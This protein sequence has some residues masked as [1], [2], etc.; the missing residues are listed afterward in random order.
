MRHTF[1]YGIKPLV[2][3]R[4]RLAIRGWLTRRKRERTGEVWPILPGS[5]RRPE[6]WPGWPEGKKFAFV[7]THDVESASGVAKCRQLMEVE[8]KWG[9]RSSF[10]FIPE[11]SYRVSRDI[12]MEL[13]HSGFEVSLHDLYHNGRLYRNRI[14]FARNAI[15]INQYLKEWGAAGFRSGF[16]FHN[17]EWLHDLDIEYD[18]STFDTDPFE[19]QPDG[20]GTIFPFWKEGSNGRGYV[21]LPY[22]LPQDST[23]FLLLRERTPAIWTRKVDW[24]ARHG[25]MALLNVHPDYIDFEGGKLQTSKYPLAYYEE[26]LQYMA[27][28]CG[29]RY[30][31][32]LPMEL[33][34]WYKRACGKARAEVKRERISAETPGLAAAKPRPKPPAA[35]DRAAVVLYAYYATDS[36]PRQEAE[37]L[38]GA[39][40]EVD[41]I[42]LRH[43][44]SDP[45]QETING[46]NVVLAPL[47]HR[48]SGKLQYVLHYGGFFLRA[49]FLL[50]KWSLKKRYKVVH[51]HNMPDFL[52]FSALAPRLRGA[53]V[54]LDLHDPMPELFAALYGVTPE[55]FASRWLRRIEKWSTGFADLVLT[56]NLSF[57]ELFASRSCPADKIEIVMNAPQTEIFHERGSAVAAAAASGVRPFKL[58]YHGLLVE[59]HGLDLALQAVASLRARIP[60]IGL[61]FYGEETEYMKAILRQVKQQGLEEAV[62]YHGFKTLPEIA[63]AIAPVDLGLVPNRLNGFTRINLPTRI[64]EYLAMNKAVIAPRTQ[65]I[66]DYFQEDELLFFEPGNGEDL[67]RKIEWVYQHPAETRAIVER[68]RRVYEKHSWDLERGRFTGLVRDMLAKS[69]GQAERGAALPKRAGNF[70]EGPLRGKKAGVVVFSYYPDDPRPRREAESLAGA[71]MEVDIICLRGQVSEPRNETVN[72]VHVRRLPFVRRRQGRL[73]YLRQYSFFLAACSAILAWRSLRKH[74]DLVHVHNM[75]DFLVFSSLVPKML[76]ASVLLDLH[77]PMPELLMSIFG[78]PEKSRSVWLLKYCEKKS[79]QFA[80]DVLT[81]NLACKKIFTSRGCPAGKLQV[82]MNTPDEKIF[83]YRPC[84]S[85]SPGEAGKPFVLMYHGSIVLRHGL[86]LAIQALQAVRRAIPG[87]E[88]RIYGSP[89]PFLES[90][91][92]QPAAA[93]EGVHYLGPRTL[94][95]I[96][97]EIDRCDLGVI[98]NRKSLFTQ[99]NT[100]TRIFEYLSRGKPIIAPEVPGITDYFGP[101]DLIFFQ[102]GDADDLAARIL[103]AYFHPQEVSKILRQGQMVY[104]HHKWSSERERFLGRVEALLAPDSS[105]SAQGKQTVAATQ[106][107]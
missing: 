11:G 85:W 44:S 21:E 66:Q 51:V 82:V 64:F 34:G 93:L 31:N 65:G 35:P 12:R 62:H 49:F 19:P 16:M 71:G 100:P 78:L 4:V 56:P 90:I 47:S 69:G 39:G 30:W 68:G 52:V 104:C 98:P 25:G 26:F 94:E 57:K 27:E 15:R 7:L 38:A 14:E 9:F 29:G 102:I 43:D 41:V 53:K 22:T 83:S 95:Q 5:E 91:L 33:A 106:R 72:G 67:A 3:A 2:P 70:P 86:D 8:K 75:P 28:A 74:Y 10:N 37:A 23:V 107:S 6:G 1:Y 55:H 96:V 48:R 24:I 36:R 88:L 13:A 99:I 92:Q 61:D 105:A 63:E 80:D 81:V 79:L 40:F 101:G 76:G 20:T 103:Y 42:S 59:R 58:M 73:T 32:P 50:A 45:A 17:L 54:I 18:T 46:V 89:T 97:Q 77:D 84:Q 60:R 87:V